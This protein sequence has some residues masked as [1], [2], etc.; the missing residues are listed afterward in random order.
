MLV[1]C[2]IFRKTTDIYIHIYMLHIYIY[3]YIYIYD[4]CNL[5]AYTHFMRFIVFVYP[6]IGCK[7][8]LAG[9]IS[10]LGGV[11]ETQYRKNMET[12]YR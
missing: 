6:M 7:P 4:M 3:I 2:P 10:E 12:V 1:V 8:I 11:Q 9:R 5:Y